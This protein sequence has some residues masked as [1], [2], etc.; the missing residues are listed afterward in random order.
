[1]KIL[2]ISSGHFLHDDRI[3]NK[4]AFTLSDMGHDVTYCAEPR[5]PISHPVM[6]FL[7]VTE[8][9]GSSGC[10]T[11]KTSDTMPPRSGRWKHRAWKVWRLL[12]HT[13][14][15]KPDLVVC[16]EFESAV[17]AWYMK[18][19]FGFSYVFDSH[20]CFQLS[21]PMR[22]PKFSQPLVHWLVTCMLKSIAKNAVA[23]TVVSPGNEEFFNKLSP[24]TPTAIL[25]NSSPLEYFPFSEEENGPVKIVHEGTFS[26]NRGAIQI[27][28]ALALLKKRDVDFC[29]LALGSVEDSIKEPFM[30]IMKDAGLE[31]R[32][33]MPGRL[34][35][36]E[37]GKVEATGQIGLICMQPLPNN[38]G[39]L[40]NKLYSYMAC[41]LA[42]VGMKSS[43]TGMMIEKYQCGVTV[44]PT[45]TKSIAE[46]INYLIE[47][48]EE[49]LEMIR[50][51]RK[52]IDEELGWHCMEEVMKEL[53][54]KVEENLK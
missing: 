50:N 5:L 15:F 36:T 23:V 4:Q 10:H 19:R 40:S 44:D 2:I 48:P 20:E 21:A 49:R 37:F 46:G 6:N 16:H 35:W 52:A 30:A 32:T 31:E 54:S 18:K 34:P 42:V 17:L 3:V 33:E 53:Y 14:Q 41:G 25:H 13:K 8:A 27:A 26:A 12:K 38:Y 28:E 11:P 51:G 9:V 24:K 29:F 22:F 7:D 43:Q 45:D 39:S 1:M 47:H